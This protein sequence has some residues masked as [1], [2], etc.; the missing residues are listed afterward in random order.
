MKVLIGLLTVFF[1]FPIQAKVILIDPGHGGSDLGAWRKIGKKKKVYEKNLALDLSKKIQKYLKKKHSVYL[2]RTFDKDISLAERAEKADKVKADIVISVHLNSSSNK[3]SNGIETFYLGNSKDTAVKKIESVEN[4]R[5]PGT[6]FIIQQILAD[7]IVSKT[8]PQSKL[9]ASKVHGKIIK[10]L[11]KKYRIKDRGIKPAIFYILALSKRPGILLEVGF[12]SNKK[13]F[14]LMSNKK[15]M[16]SYAK[17][18]AEGVEA[19]F[20]ETSKDDINLF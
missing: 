19:Y 20:A 17:A 4:E 11:K 16:D 5:M 9:L 14:K 1:I 7:L 15:F 18:V 2:S 13:E 8:V 10:K 6:S 3:R 12:M